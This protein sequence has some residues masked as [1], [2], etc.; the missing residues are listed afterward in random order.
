[1]DSA[2]INDWLQVV[3]LFGVIASLIFVG[4]QMKQDREIALSAISQARTEATMQ[5]INDQMSNPYLMSA[6]AKIDDGNAEPLTSSERRAVMVYGQHTLYNFENIHYQFTNG[7]VDEEHWT[8]ARATLKM[9]FGS[10][11]GVR[12]SFEAAPENWRQ[13][14]R[15]AVEEILAELDAEA[16]Q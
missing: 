12:E 7:F 16:G 1:M 11:E 3:G 8:K 5:A 13:S 4:L 10:N 9:L 15:S 14:F 2:K 6:W